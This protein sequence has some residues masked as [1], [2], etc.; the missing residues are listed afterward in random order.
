MTT[1]HINSGNPRDR[2]SFNRDWRFDLVQEPV[3]DGCNLAYDTMRRHLLPTA[4]PW[5]EVPTVSPDAPPPSPLRAQADFDDSPWRELSLPHD[6]GVEGPFRQEHP[7][8]TGKLQ[9]WGVAWY[10]KT[11]RLLAG[12]DDDRWYLDIDGAMSHALLWV[13][14]RFAGGWPY[15][16][17]SFRIDLTPHLNL[18][19]S[20][21]IAVRL[22]NPPD[23]SRWYPGGGIYR[24][25]W[26]V[27]NAP[28]H[29]DQWGVGITTPEVNLEKARIE[30]ATTVRNTENSDVTVNVKTEFFAL[31]ENGRP[32]SKPVATNGPESVDIKAGEPSIQTASAAISRPALWS[33][34]SPNRYLAIT[35]I[36]RDGVVLDRC[37][38]PFGL[39]TIAVDPAKGLLLNGEPLRLNGVCQHHDLGALGA[40]LHLDAMER[41]LDLLQEMGVNAIR[42]THNPPAPE[43]L[44]S[45]DRR[46]LLVIDEAFDTWAYSKKPNDYHRLFPDWHEADLRAMVRRDRNHPC[47]ILWSSGN[48]IAEQAKPEGAET[49]RRLAAIIKSEDPTRPITVGCNIPE[50]CRNG[51]QHTMDVYGFNYKPHEYEDFVR[52]H[53]DIPFYGSETASTVSSRGEYVFPVSDDKADGRANF[54][55]SSYDLYAPGWATAPDV[56][57]AAQ[58]RNP[59][60]L[61]EFVWTGF[62]YLGEPTPYNSDSTNLLNFSD[63][64]QK[65]RAE[66][67]LAEMGLKTFPSRSSYFG[68]IDL[69]GFKKDRFYLYQARWRPDHPT[70]HLVPHWTWPGREGEVTPVHVY[71]SGDEAELFLNGRSLGRRKKDPFT[72]RLRWDDVVYE[73]GELKVI[74]FKDGKTWAENVQHTAGPAAV[75]RLS[76]ERA[77]R[78]DAHA[79]HQLAFVTASVLDASGKLVPQA[80]LPVTFTVS[81][82]AELSATDNGDPTSHVPFASPERDTF[83]GFALAIVRI[84]A[85]NEEPAIIRA[86]SPGLKAAETTLNPAGD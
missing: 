10:R 9:W 20:N 64:E 57:F 36:E 6:W 54:Q 76:V 11:F 22:D 50:S 48:E 67:E 72:Y 66:K 25:V 78:T 62:D 40:A 38:T 85:K 45:C 7:G 8:E 83:N 13:N 27:R 34:A 24:N 52:R 60:S 61:G 21:V 3:A 23:S 17:A 5:R 37:E 63:P 28:V 86:D 49:S 42:T 31:D 18:N 80:K 44:D 79:Q 4:N 59:T 51:F 33:T 56:E 16:Y 75:L 43:L 81:G 12:A 58:D 71:T 70:A 77:R 82:P 15:G 69:A 41:Q 1:S 29:I 55:V 65:A 53:R 19:G 32:E 46:G 2:H 73:P 47:V 84:P 26:L 74:A 68:I 39:R 14:G 35:S 30:V